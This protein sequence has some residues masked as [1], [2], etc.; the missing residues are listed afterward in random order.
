MNDNPRDMAF[1]HEVL[2]IRR[3]KQCLI[4]I[5]G[6]KILAHSP[7]LNQ[8]RSDLNRH[9]S[10]RL[11]A[12]NVRGESGEMVLTISLTLAVQWFP[13]DQIECDQ[14]D[15]VG[16]IK[17]R[18]PLAQTTSLTSFAPDN[19]REMLELPDPTRGGYV[20]S[21]RPPTV[22]NLDCDRLGSLTAQSLI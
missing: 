15:L 6:A 19:L 4:D 11:L 17:P 18:R 3:Q 9:Y 16:S 14:T 5:R 1:R 20:D 21:P 8:T 2:H 12:L 13:N 7:S 22:A 10:D